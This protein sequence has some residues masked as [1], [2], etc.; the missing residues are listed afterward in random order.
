MRVIRNVLFLGKPGSG[1]GTQ[2]IRLAQ[3]T[4]RSHVSSGEYFRTLTARTDDIGERVR[5][6]L[7]SGGLVLDPFM[8]YLLMGQLMGPDSARGT[9][10]DGFGRTPPQAKEFNSVHEWF[11]WGYL[12]VLLELPDEVARSRLLGRN[13]GREDDG[14]LEQI[15]RRL[16]IYEELTAPAIP[17]FEAAG[18]LRRIDSNRSIEAVDADIRALL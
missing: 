16:R 13:A 6:V 9:V 12:V 7:K 4:H 15:D 17:I 8:T 14:S 5:D 11:G 1:K 18:T 2:G 10:F 3:A